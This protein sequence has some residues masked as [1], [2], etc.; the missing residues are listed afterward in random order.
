MFRIPVHSSDVVLQVH[1]RFECLST[2]LAHVRRDSA[3]VRLDVQ[4][5]VSLGFEHTAA[6]RAFMLA[7]FSMH[8]F[9]CSTARRMN[10][11]L[12]TEAALKRT[13]SRV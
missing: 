12:V 9:M 8:Q 5:Q 13:L 4:I 10:E 7:S 6:S 3:V 11:A 2:L 1:G